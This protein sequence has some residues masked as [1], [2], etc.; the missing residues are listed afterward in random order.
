MGDPIQT[1]TEPR[2]E[3]TR[4][5]AGIATLLGGIVLGLGLLF[6]M[7]AGVGAIWS[8]VTASAT[9]SASSS[10]GGAAPNGA[11]GSAAASNSGMSSMNQ[12]GASSATGSAPAAGAAPAGAVQDVSLVVDPPPLGGRK[13]PDGHVYDAFV[14]ATFSM[15]VGVTAKVT[16]LNYD[17]LPHTWTSPG[18]GVNTMVP[19]GSST[20]PSRTTF[21]IHPTKAGTFSWYCATPCDSFAMKTNG[22]M[23]GTVTVTA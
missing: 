10:S 13:G 6:G 11:S 22:F 23:R 1:G 9:P 7:A 14:P 18:L 19:A 3:P 17:T 21:T 2:T 12:S 16:V 15:K 8:S 5:A 20:S 4:Y